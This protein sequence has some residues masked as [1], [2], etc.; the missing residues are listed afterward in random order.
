MDD[1]RFRLLRADD[2]PATNPLNLKYKFGLQDSK[3]NIAAAVR[4][5]GYI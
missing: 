2:V 4:R 1:V 3:G 5:A